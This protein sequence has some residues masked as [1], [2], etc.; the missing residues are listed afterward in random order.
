MFGSRRFWNDSDLLS[1]MEEIAGKSRRRIHNQCF[2]LTSKSG[3]D[4]RNIAIEEVGIQM[5]GLP[6]LWS[7]G[8]GS[9]V[10]GADDRLHVPVDGVDLC[11][12]SG[13][14]YVDQGFRVSENEVPRAAAEP[15]QQ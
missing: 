2:T 14:L 5:P 8:A 11:R 3:D 13:C 4:G 10:T 15:P 9:V 6:I 1:K 7:T 12:Q